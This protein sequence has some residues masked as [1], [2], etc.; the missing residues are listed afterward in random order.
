L[1][2]LI[3]K[4][5]VGYAFRGGWNFQQHAGK[6][7]KWLWKGTTTYEQTSTHYRPIERFRS[8]EFERTWMPALTNQS[9]KDTGYREHLAEHAGCRMRPS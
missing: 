5:N 3:P 2:F 9:V 8:V 4:Q 7:S 1:P 6:D